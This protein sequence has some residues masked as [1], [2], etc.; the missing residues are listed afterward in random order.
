MTKHATLI[1]G[2]L[3]VL[4]VTIIGFL[5]QPAEEPQ[6]SAR[7]LQEIKSI[8]TDQEAYFQQNG[9]YLQIEEGNRLPE[10]Y[11]DTETVKT[12]LGKDIPPEYTVHTYKL[13]NGERGYII[14][15]EDEQ[16]AYKQR[17]GTISDTKPLVSPKNATS[18]P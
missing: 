6:L 16:N 9:E 10:R 15:W 13:P 3:A 4:V 2:F 7:T 8:K 12:K 5:A 11:S 1:S 17:F 18:T 14:Y